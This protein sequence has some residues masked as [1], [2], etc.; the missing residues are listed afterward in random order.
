[1]TKHITYNSSKTGSGKTEFII[2]Q[3]VKSQDNN[4]II[5]P[6][7]KLCNEIEK[8]LTKAGENSVITLHQ[9]TIS[10]PINALKS[11]M[12]NREFKN[13]I[14]THAS[15]LTAF[16]EGLSMELLWNLYIDEDLSPVIEDEIY[17]THLSIP[18]F[19]GMFTFT[20][21][22][23][24]E[25]YMI[26]K[27]ISETITDVI[28]DHSV[29]DNILGSPHF[30]KMAK[31]IVS[32]NLTTKMSKKMYD[33][34][35][36]AV[37]DTRPT[38]DFKVT[39]VSFLHSTPLSRFKSIN[40]SSSFYDLTLS[41]Q[42]F[43]KLGFKML[44]Q[45]FTSYHNRTDFS[46]VEINYFVDENWSKKVRTA[47]VNGVTTQEAI[48]QIINKE[49][50]NAKYIYNTN[51]DSRE[52][53]G[54]TGQ[55]VT[56]IHG[57]NSY[58]NV[59]NVVYMPSLNASGELVNFMSSMGIGRKNIDFDRNVL[60]AYQFVSRSAIRDPNNKE[61]IRIYV[62]DKRTAEFLHAT[63]GGSI[64]KQ[65]NVKKAKV[66][67]PANIRSFVSRVKSRLKTGEPLRHSTMKKYNDILV[68][69]YGKTI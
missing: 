15:F 26:M 52:A 34:M 65:H 10:N 31:S 12:A 56:H 18:F 42:I 3:I 51:V 66:T 13:I 59:R 63:Y 22:P 45:D 36:D 60:S 53:F 33:R 4:I 9:D 23:N 69:Y 47:K 19:M 58:S 40:I 61:K 6:N 50:Q 67:I 46:N 62:M 35:V 28:Q 39:T 27:P 57:V 64:M 7:K 48:S 21:D 32:E 25:E 41:Y 14:T 5:A 2:N 49:L 55:L 29:I 68:K 20:Q 43:E 44:K 37:K 30:R 16:N 24:F 38:K 11:Y 54:F 17:L 8:R 1:M